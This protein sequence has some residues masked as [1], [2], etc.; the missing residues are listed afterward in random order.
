LTESLSEEKIVVSSDPSPSHEKIADRRT[1][2]YETLVDP[3]V[4]RLKGEKLKTWMFTKYFF[5]KP[6]PDEIQLVSINKYY[7]PFM[8]ISGKY[9]IDYYRK[10]AYTVKLDKE[11]QDVII[12]SQQFQPEQT[13]DSLGE[14]RSTIKV[15]GEEHVKKEV[16]ASLVLNRS[17]RNV[18]SESL[19]SG[20]SERN[21]EKILTECG[22]EEIPE[23]IDLDVIQSKILKRPKDISRIVDELI[24]VNERVVIYSPRFRLVYKDTVTGK[25][26]T[27]EFDGITAKR[28]HVYRGARKPQNA[29][30]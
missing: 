7:E 16:A 11:V 19:P 13:I 8:V 15:E 21:P 30:Q 14:N 10:S 28:I 4:I 29:Q 20:T 26:K 17:G 1:I 23:D 27:I 25:E 5:L 3:T 24:E 9:A 18:S 6:S 22:I 2:V 12:L